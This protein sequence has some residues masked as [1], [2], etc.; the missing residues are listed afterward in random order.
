MC[1]W[2]NTNLCTVF[3]IRLL[4]EHHI[5]KDKRRKDFWS[6]IDLD[7]KLTQEQELQSN[8]IRHY[9]T[10]SQ[11]MTRADNYSTFA[12]GRLEPLLPSNCRLGGD[13]NPNL[14][15]FYDSMTQRVIYCYLWTYHTKRLYFMVHFN[16]WHTLTLLP[17]RGLPAW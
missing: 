15:I 1:E 7:N 4:L 12:I 5:I 13:S 2:T 14:L 6:E 10:S 9:C 3:G 11:F 17:P 8:P 16:L